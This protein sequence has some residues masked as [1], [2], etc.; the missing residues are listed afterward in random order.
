MPAPARGVPE[1]GLHPHLAKAP[2]YAQHPLGVRRAGL[3]SAARGGVPGAALLE[4]PGGMRR[5]RGPLRPCRLCLLGSRSR[6]TP[7]LVRSK[8]TAAGHTAAP[9]RA[10]QAAGEA[11]AAAGQ[12]R[13]Q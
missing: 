9:R 12:G 5:P 13:W 3:P 11:R 2:T 8:Q 6:V 4:P 10:A 1:P 7:P